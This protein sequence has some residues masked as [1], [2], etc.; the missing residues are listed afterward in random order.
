[1][2]KTKD[3]IIKKALI[4]G[5]TGSGGSYLADYIVENQPEVEL[6]GISRWHSTSSLKNL[7]KSIDKIILHECDLT[8]F[9][10]VF[11]IL[12]KVKPDAIFHLAS[13]ANVR[14]SFETPLSVINNNV[15]STA[16]LLEAIKMAKIS[17]IIQLCSCYDKDTEVLTKRGFLKYD[18]IKK[19]DLVISIDPDTKEV[20]YRPIKKIII[21]YYES[22]MKSIKG[23]S[24]D[25]LITPN[26]NII[27][28]KKPNGK[29][30]FQK[31]KDLKAPKSRFYFPKGNYRGKMEDKIRV[32]NKFY[33]TKDVLYLTGLY[34]GDGYSGM[35]LKKSNNKS[36]L[37][38]SDFLKLSRNKKGRFIA[39][40]FGLI[41]E[42]V[43][44]SYRVFLAIPERDK[45]RLSAI[46]C[47]NRLGINY[48]LYKNEIYF[49]SK[50]FVKFFDDVGH[51]SAAK[52]IP[53]WI[54]EYDSYYL[55]FLYK[56]LIDSDGYYYTT[57]ERFHT[58]SEK[59]VES[60]TKLCLFTGRFVTV[61]KNK[62]PKL[63][64]FGQRQIKKARDLYTFSISKKSRLV[65]GRNIKETTYKGKIWCLEI[66]GTHNFV[67]RRNG[68]TVFCGN[69]SEVYGQVDKKNVPIKETCPF[70]PASPYAISKVT[71]DLMGYTYF[72]SYNMKIIRTRMFAYLNPRRRDLF[73]TSFA[74]QVA[75]IEAG[76]QKMLLHGNL[77]SVRTIIDVR[78]AME[79]YWVATKKC[80]FGEAYNIGGTTVMKVEEYL[81]ELK[82]LSTCKIP[83]RPDKKL[84]RPADV[85]LQIPDTTKF[86]KQTGWKPKYSFKESVQHLLDYC[87]NEV[88]K[89]AVI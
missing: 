39:G 64:R 20:S 25:L 48:K 67:V 4:T 7:E 74:M 66:E 28:S 31:V 40:K 37:N 24:V 87:R 77:D 22:A 30:F 11:S 15:M 32:G 46:N 44:H 38:R 53:D 78:D 34:I 86:T 50:D 8:D 82:K 59:L 14:A 2:K 81:E 21:Q 61:C 72:K 43:Q 60:F 27:F 36:G 68:K 19:D 12:K 75:R 35:S 6:H 56:G 69:S 89:Y 62:N 51:S 63:G 57:G 23:R 1:M 84:F 76:L 54:F 79:S 85:T 47:L 13:Y 80:E 58:V 65:E 33:S 49:S 17:P 5:I 41:E 10:S 70:N 73:A 83:A 3:R 55:D 88:K 42:S 52:N 26:H 9:S 18:K 16:N 29:L 45:S 71:Q